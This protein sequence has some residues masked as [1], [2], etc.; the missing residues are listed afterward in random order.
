MIANFWAKQLKENNE[1][2]PSSCNYF[3]VGQLTTRDNKNSFTVNQYYSKL[4]P[5]LLLTSNKYTMFFI[6]SHCVEGVG[7]W[8][9]PGWRVVLNVS[10]KEDSDW[11]G[12]RVCQKS[13]MIGV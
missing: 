3:E 12:L 7:D 6:L 4:E 9:D 5:K 10:S 8:L 11:K 13:V 2:C 1:F